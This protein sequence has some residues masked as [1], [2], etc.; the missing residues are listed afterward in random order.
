VRFE[1][2]FFFKNALANYNVDVLV[3]DSDAIPTILSYNSGVVKLTTPRHATPRHKLFDDT[4]KS[5]VVIE[6]LHL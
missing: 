5:G 4:A 3:V 6:H 1:F 2:F